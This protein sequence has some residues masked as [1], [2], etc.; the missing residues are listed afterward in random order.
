MGIR[1]DEIFFCGAAA[2][3]DEIRT[4][5]K[6]DRR[7]KYSCV[8]LCAECVFFPLHCKNN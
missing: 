3:T 4:P 6:I 7:Q 5:H 8:I 2:K 1:V